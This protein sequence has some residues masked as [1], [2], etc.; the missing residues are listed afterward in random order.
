MTLAELIDELPI[1]GMSAEAASLAVRGIQHDAASVVPG[2]LFVGW[3]G[4]RFDGASF[5]ELA[6][7]RGAVAV[8]TDREV[9]APA[10]AS[11]R[12]AIPRELLAPLA[13]RLYQH[14]DRDLRLV[15]VTGTN[16]KSTTVA[17]VQSILEHAGYPCG[18]MGTLGYRFGE[19]DL[20]SGRT[21]PE[22]D[23]FFR[24]LRLM[25]DRGAA[26]V[27]L[28]VASHA[29]VQGRVAGAQFEIGVF[30]NL[31]QDHLDFHRD[32]ESY[33][34]AKRRL[35]DQLRP[36]GRAVVN[37]DD[38]WGQ[39]L[40]RE[41]G[42]RALTFGE[43]GG[44][45]TVASAELS[46]SGSRAELSTPRGRLVVR[47]RLLGRYNL[48]NVLAAVATGEA[49]ELEPSAIVEGI[50]AQ[51]PVRGRLEP[52]EL[53]Q[54][55]P[56]LI[57]Y[58]H[59][60]GGIEAA[61]LALRELWPGRIAIVFGCGG[62]RDRTKRP[63]MGHAAASA[64]LAIITDDNP[65]REDPAAIRAEVIAA[66]SACGARYEERSPRKDAIR[67]ALELA[68]APDPSAESEHAWA[69]VVA[70]KGHEQVQIVGDRE[71]PFSDQVEV[72]RILGELLGSAARR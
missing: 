8:L 64:D 24:T 48:W 15:A 35:F 65:R 30:T 57:D 69:V 1:A 54:G 26:A 50:A 58:A 25:R 6:A 63:L 51:A 47:S 33:F 53:G 2:D 37:Q 32:L 43:R 17:L 49:L 27:A 4:A 23:D 38:P 42:S 18:V 31:T 67:L 68:A 70:G 13:A 19:L 34:L 62:E 72:E 59:T 20:G 9:D 29:L 3:Q 55:F 52:I 28:E 7:R 44:D 12:A 46:L 21:T 16:G 5:V 56:V 66:L 71:L 41:L 22:G 61:L 39:R 45:V 11:L 14:P 40:A 10:V 60:P 36:G